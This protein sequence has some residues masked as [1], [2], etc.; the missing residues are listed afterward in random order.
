MPLLYRTLYA[1]VSPVLGFFLGLRIWECYSNNLYMEVLVLSLLLYPFASM[2]FL[3]WL[4][5]QEEGRWT[6]PFLLQP[7]SWKVSWHW[8]QGDLPGHSL[9]SC[10]LQWDFVHFTNLFMC[11]VVLSES[12]QLKML[13]ESRNPFIIKF[14]VSSI[15]LSVSMM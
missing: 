11:G 3:Y 6:L 1:D 12:V 7:S 9:P 4:L 15:S 14:C 2:L 5:L 8:I 13:A 10:E